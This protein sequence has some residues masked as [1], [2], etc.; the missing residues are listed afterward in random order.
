MPITKATHF[1]A[2]IKRQEVNVSRHKNSGLGDEYQDIVI[3]IDGKDHQMTFD[4]FLKRLT[5]PL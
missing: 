4:E 5:L 2:E 3:R 1:F